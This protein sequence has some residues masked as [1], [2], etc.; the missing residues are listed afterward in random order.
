MCGHP[1]RGRCGGHRESGRFVTRHAAGVSRFTHASHGI[2]QD[3]A[4]FVDAKDPVKF[5]LLTL[6]NRTGRPRRLS[7]FAYNEWSLGPPRPREHL[8]VITEF[9]RETGAVLATNPY[10]QECAGRVAFT[11]ASEGP[12]SATGDRLSFLG[13]NGSLARPAAV[14]PP[15]LVGP[16]R[17]GARSLRR[18]PGR[19]RPGSGRKP[20]PCLP[21][22]ARQGSRACPRAD[23]PPRQCDRRGSRAQSRCS[24][25]GPTPWRRS[26]C[27]PRMTPS[28][29]S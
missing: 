21:A 15:R 19:D 5:S 26:R 23:A 20:P 13:R 6:T 24:R 9:D 10:N 14:R 12:S 4:V 1:R 27:A 18:A 28:I 16:V 7:V 3:L 2:L 17:G 11:H 29:S 22:G 25:S 8:H